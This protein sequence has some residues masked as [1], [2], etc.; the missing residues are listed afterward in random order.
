MLNARTAE[1]T[2]PAN[3]SAR[4]RIMSRENRCK[5]SVQTM[6]L[7]ADAPVDTPA[8]ALSRS[9]DAS[10]RKELRTSREGDRHGRLRRACLTASSSNPPSGKFSGEPF[11]NLFKS[12]FIP[13]YSRL[14]PHICYLACL[15]ETG[16]PTLRRRTH[17]PRAASEEHPG[18]AE[19]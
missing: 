10:A 4:G 16:A 14:Y 7:P 6:N 9:R 11:G 2:P 5:R 8:A 19:C 18:R 13:L 3:G 1:K 15:C 12:R 17:P